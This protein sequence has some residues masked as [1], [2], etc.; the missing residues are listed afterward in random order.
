LRERGPATRLAAG[1]SHRRGDKD[2]HP[3]FRGR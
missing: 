2:D 1:G 3:R